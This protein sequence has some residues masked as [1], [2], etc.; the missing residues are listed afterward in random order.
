M[1]EDVSF[2]VRIMMLLRMMLLLFLKG[3]HLGP[4]SWISGFVQNLK[5][6]P[7]VESKVIKT[8]NNS[9]K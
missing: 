2:E 3:G 4:P 5:K 1:S 7:K 6:L 8:N 9:I